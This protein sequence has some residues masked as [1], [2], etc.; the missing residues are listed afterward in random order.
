MGLL[1]ENKRR[2]QSYVDPLFSDSHCS[3]YRTLQ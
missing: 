2:M 1:L 3:N